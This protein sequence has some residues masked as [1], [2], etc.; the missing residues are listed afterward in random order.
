MISVG[1]DRVFS[2]RMALCRDF[3]GDDFQPLA[4]QIVNPRGESEAVEFGECL[5]G[6]ERFT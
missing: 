2:E 1:L 5:N 6:R 3:R 4:F